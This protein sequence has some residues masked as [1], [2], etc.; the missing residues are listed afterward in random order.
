MTHCNNIVKVGLIGQ[1]CIL[2]GYTEISNATWTNEEVWERQRSKV[3][4]LF[5]FELILGRGLIEGGC[6][7]KGRTWRD[8]EVSEVGVHCVK[9]P[10][11][12]ELCY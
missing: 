4:F 2:H 9:F 5:C 8:L 12:K 3:S 7:G 1:K 10:I 6:R 11:D